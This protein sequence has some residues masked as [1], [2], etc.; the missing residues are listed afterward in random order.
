MG[1]LTFT[2]KYG[3]AWPRINDSSTDS[4]DGYVWMLVNF[5]CDEFFGFA[6]L[7]LLTKWIKNERLRFY[8]L[9]SVLLRPKSTMQYE[10][11]PP[12]RNKSLKSN[13]QPPDFLDGDSIEQNAI[14]LE[15]QKKQ[16]I[17]HTQLILQ[18]QKSITSEFV[19]V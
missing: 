5:F 6:V 12:P 19:N 16:H 9:H 15:S 1:I 17:Q 18:K 3:L 10:I 8:K 11:N 13:N 2:L 4:W 7:L 14:L